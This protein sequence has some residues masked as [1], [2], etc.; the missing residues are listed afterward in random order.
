MFKVK[1]RNARCGICSKLAIKTPERHKWCRSRVL[2]ANFEH[3][4][5]QV[6]TYWEQDFD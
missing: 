5:D 6:N 3:N 2:N 1:N 4:F